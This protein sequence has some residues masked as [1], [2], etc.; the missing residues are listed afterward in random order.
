MV[1]VLAGVC[2][3]ARTSLA[4]V[5]VFLVGAVSA[6]LRRKLLIV[7]DDRDLVGLLADIVEQAGVAALPAQDPPTATEGFEREPPEAML[8]DLMLGPWDGFDPLRELCR[9]AD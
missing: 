3:P 1:S 8:L 9:P 6:D 2:F 4:Q 7:D 5:G